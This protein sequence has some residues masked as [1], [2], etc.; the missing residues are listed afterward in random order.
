MKKANFI[1]GILASIVV[2]LGAF[3]FVKADEDEIVT[4]KVTGFGTSDSE[5]H[6]DGWTKAVS[7]VVG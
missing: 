7:Q 3:E 5:A 4:V 1:L 6:N 2:I